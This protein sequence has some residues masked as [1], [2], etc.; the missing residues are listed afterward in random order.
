MRTPGSSR[1]GAM[2]WRTARNGV[3]ASAAS[4]VAAI[5]M[6]A[7]QGIQATR[8]DFLVIAGVL[9]MLLLLYSALRPEL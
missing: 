7:F 5:A 4:L 1:P 3:F 8:I 6:L 9:V 2:T